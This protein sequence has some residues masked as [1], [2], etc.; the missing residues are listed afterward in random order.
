MFM[1]TAEALTEMQEILS[2]LE[3]MLEYADE[4]EIEFCA[5][6]LESLH[7]TLFESAL[8]LKKSNNCYLDIEM[9]NHVSLMVIRARQT[10]QEAEAIA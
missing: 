4:E 5:G 8:Q 6:D 2:T 10:I 1:T 7:N 3:M 9:R